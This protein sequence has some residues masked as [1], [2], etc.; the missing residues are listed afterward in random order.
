MSLMAGLELYLN[1]VSLI[2]RGSVP[3]WDTKVSVALT[4]GK[5]PTRPLTSS[6]PKSWHISNNTSNAAT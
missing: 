4:L 1:M 5:D 6:S 3:I 2:S